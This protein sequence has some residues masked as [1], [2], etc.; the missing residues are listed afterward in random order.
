M[1]YARF[2]DADGAISG[3]RLTFGGNILQRSHIAYT[4]L[5]HELLSQLHCNFSRSPILQ[6]DYLRQAAIAQGTVMTTTTPLSLGR[7]FFDS[8]ETEVLS[9]AF[10]KAWAF[11]EFDP[12]LGVLDASERQSRLARCMMALLKIGES[13]PTSLANSAIKTLR[14]NRQSEVRSQRAQTSSAKALDAIRVVPLG[15]A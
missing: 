12:M 7:D 11:V 6:T 2:F 10:L 13:D 15:R 8:A 5:P 4:T 3:V 14:R 9:T 1:V